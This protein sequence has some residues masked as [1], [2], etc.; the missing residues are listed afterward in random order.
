MNRDPE[1]DSTV[2]ASISL[3]EALSGLWGEFTSAGGARFRIVVEGRPK[4]VQPAIQEQICLIARE[5]LVNALRHSEATSIEAEV[6]YLPRR[7]GVVVR[8]DGRGID[9]KVARAGRDR[10]WGLLEMHKRAESMGA[11]LWIWSRPG[12]GTEV[13]IWIPGAIAVQGPVTNFERRASCRTSSNG[14]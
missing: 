9:P 2:I 1:Q 8:D 3:E 14:K 5:A 6:R 11:Q 12:A 10:L 4:T 13:E 7:L